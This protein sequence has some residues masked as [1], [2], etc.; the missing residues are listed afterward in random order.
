MDPESDQLLYSSRTMDAVTLNPGTL[1]HCLTWTG[2][3]GGCCLLSRVPVENCP[4][5]YRFTKQRVQRSFYGLAWFC[6]DLHSMSLE[7]RAGSQSIYFSSEPDITR[8][9][10]KSVSNS[11]TS[12]KHVERI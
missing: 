12:T 11:L 1:Y 5:S 8:T 10:H 4:P 7:T 9:S 2:S 6:H 3:E